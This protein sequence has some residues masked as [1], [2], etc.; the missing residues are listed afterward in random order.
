MLIGLGTRFPAGSISDFVR[1]EGGGRGEGGDSA[2]CMLC[3]PFVTIICPV[4]KPRDYY[5]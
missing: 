1:R 3:E 4:R 2:F 5:C